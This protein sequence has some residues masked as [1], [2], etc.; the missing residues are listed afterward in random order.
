MKLTR[1]TTDGYSN[2]RDG[3]ADALQLRAQHTDNFVLTPFHPTPLPD[4]PVW[5]DFRRTM[6]G[7]KL[8]SLAYSTTES[9]FQ[10]F[11]VVGHNIRI[12]IVKANLLS[13]FEMGYATDLIWPC[14]SPIPRFR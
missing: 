10:S 1:T 6:S 5:S 7:I 4:K 8:H 14:S 12:P 3:I 9:W 13:A 11:A 2:R